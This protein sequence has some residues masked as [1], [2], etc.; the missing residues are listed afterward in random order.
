MLAEDK[1]TSATGALA[2]KLADN[3]RDLRLNLQSVLGEGILS[4]AQ[5]WGTAVAAAATSRN[6]AL[7]AAILADARGQVSVATIDD[8]LAA[9]ALMGMNNILYRFRHMIGKPSYG[10]KPARLRM[11]R[12]VKPAGTKIDFEL[13]ALA[14]SAVGGCEACVRAHEK[15]VVEGGL[16]EDHVHEAVR[17]ASVVHGVAIA[18][19]QG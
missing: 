17:I 8:A 12:L 5:R 19:E 16:G 1:P 4:P 6:P 2:E 14:A 9:S 11:N 7:T 13:F 3:A 15:V 18:L 10:E